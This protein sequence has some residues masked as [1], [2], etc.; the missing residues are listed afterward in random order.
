MSTI[1][2]SVCHIYEL[3]FLRKTKMKNNESNFVFYILQERNYCCSKGK[4]VKVRNICC[5]KGSSCWHIRGWFNVLWRNIRQSF[6]PDNTWKI[7]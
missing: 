2:F 6:L 5:R 7:F 3:L 4:L 1:L